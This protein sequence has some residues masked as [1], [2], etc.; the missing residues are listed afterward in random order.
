MDLSTTW[1][2]LCE[3]LI[4]KHKIVHIQVPRCR[5]ITADFTI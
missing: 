4:E 3:V 5:F 2:G 1:M